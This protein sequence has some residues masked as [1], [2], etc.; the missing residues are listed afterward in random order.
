[1]IIAAVTMMQD[2]KFMTDQHI[3]PGTE[4]ASCPIGWRTRTRTHNA[5]SEGPGS[6]HPQCP[7]VRFE[8]MPNHGFLLCS[9]K[10]IH[11]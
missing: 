7:A 9:P 5:H 8:A 2:P 3:A 1:M 4:T 6:P 11:L 10:P